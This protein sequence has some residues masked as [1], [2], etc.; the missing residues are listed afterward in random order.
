MKNNVPRENYGTTDTSDLKG[1]MTKQVSCRRSTTLTNA[2]YSL[3][4]L[5]KLSGRMDQ[6]VFLALLF[7]LCD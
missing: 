5:T 4:Q 3:Y 7:A 1:I 6:E 2:L